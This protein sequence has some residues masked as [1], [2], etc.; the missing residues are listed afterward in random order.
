MLIKTEG[1][2]LRNRKY[3]ETDSMLVIFTKKVGKINAIAK[4]ARRTKS[5]LLAGVQP[6]SYS[7]FVLFKGRSL[8]TVNQTEPKEIFYNLREDV[9]RLSYAAY[10]LELVE[11]VTEEGQ[12]NNRLFNLLGRTLHLMK[13]EEIELETIL[14]A[15][16]LKL[17]EYSGLKPHLTSCVSCGQTSSNSWRFSSKE[18]GL[19]CHQCHGIDSFSIKINVL[20]VK[21]ANYLLA[22][23]MEEIQK[24]KVNPYLHESLN[25][26]LKQYI[27]VHLDRV[28]FNSL[29]IAK[30]I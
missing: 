8:Y 11:S 21:L 10:L 24:L 26:V 1:F 9:K 30:K 25:K 2:V 3:G 15:F 19:I 5:A 29:E 13:K 16:E 23:D 14:R 17:M 28:N 7:D 22:K 20:T 6:F 12:T 4:G 27:M 18:G